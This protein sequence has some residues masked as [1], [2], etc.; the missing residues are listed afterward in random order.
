MSRGEEAT[1]GPVSRGEAGPGEGWK[2]ARL[3]DGSHNR[4]TSR[5]AVLLGTAGAVAGGLALSACTSTSNEPLPTTTT[6]GTI[7]NGTPTRGEKVAALGAS[8]ENL[9]VYA[10]DEGLKAAQLTKGAAS[11]PP[12]L[13]LLVQ[14]ARDHHAQHAARWNQLLASARL[15]PVTNPD[16]AVA[17]AV[18]AMLAGI[19]DWLGLAQLALYLE[20]TLAQTYQAAVGTLG[21][22]PAAAEIAATIQPVEME[23]AAILYLV[24]GR[25]PG[26]Q[27]A[28]SDNYSS[29]EALAFSPLG[30]ARSVNDYPGA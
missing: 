22:V 11:S 27:G 13:P 2:N 15:P 14:T 5:R 29:G 1:G 25:Y 7:P 23:H 8:L 30:L 12:G 6:A 10:Y 26:T 16:P 9:A 21:P 17:P 28:V 19:S 3:A 24:M 20:S 4:G 18:N